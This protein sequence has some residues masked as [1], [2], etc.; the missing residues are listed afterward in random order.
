MEH[1]VNGLVV[2]PI[3]QTIAEAIDRLY[4]DRSATVR[5]GAANERRLSDLNIDW[6]TVVDALTS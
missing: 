4:R 1:E 6:S 5:M 2:P 3:P